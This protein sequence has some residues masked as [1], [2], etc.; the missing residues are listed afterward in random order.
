MEIISSDRAS[1]LVNGSPMK[2]F[3]I[4]RGLGQGDPFSPFLFILAINGLH[5]ALER[6]HEWLM[7]LVGFLLMTLR[8]HTFYMQMM[9]LCFHHEVLRIFP[10]LFAFFRCFFLTSGLKINLHKRTLI[11]VSATPSQV[12]EVASSIGCASDFP[13]FIHLRVHVGHN[14]NWVN[15]WSTIIDKFYSRLAGWKAKCLSFVGRL[16]LIKL[17]LWSVSNYL[18]SVFPALVMVL[19]SLESFRA[20]FFR[21]ADLDERR[22]HWLNWNKTST[23]RELGGLGVR[24]LF[25]F[26]KPLMFRWC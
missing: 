16:T 6:G 20:K 9:L 1:I 8:S 5:V 22:M 19:R 12:V 10:I 3:H 2:E 25:A 24:S 21:G 13:P 4:Q 17:V 11:R 18:M 26:N 14:M 15:A 23:S 7:F